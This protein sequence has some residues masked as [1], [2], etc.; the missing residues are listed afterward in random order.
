MLDGDTYSESYRASHSQRISWPTMARPST[1]AIARRCGGTSNSPCSKAYCAPSEGRSEQVHECFLKRSLLLADH[2]LGFVQDSDAAEHQ[3]DQAACFHAEKSETKIDASIFSSPL[4]CL[5]ADQSGRQLNT[6]LG[7]S[8]RVLIAPFLS[9]ADPAQGLA[10]LE[11]RSP[12][13][14]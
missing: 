6:I 1:L 7:A 9:T 8:F 4:S 14:Q 11:S 10:I 5:P 3:S 13:E 12:V 2:Q